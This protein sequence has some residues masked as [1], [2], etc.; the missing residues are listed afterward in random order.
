MLLLENMVVGS[1]TLKIHALAPR[2][3]RLQV[4]KVVSYPFIITLIALEPIHV[5]DWEL[6]LEPQDT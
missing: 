5:I 1:D 6:L 2:P 3:V 4:S